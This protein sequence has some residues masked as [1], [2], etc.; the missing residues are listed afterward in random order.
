MAYNGL[1]TLTDQRLSFSPTGRLDRIVGVRELEV[2]IS[3]ITHAEI[4]GIEKNLVVEFEDRSARFAGQGAKRVFSRLDALLNESKTATTTIEFQPGERVLVQ[5][6]ATSYANGLIATRG[7]V[8]LT[9]KRIRF[10]T[11]GGLETLIWTFPELD[12]PLEAITRAELSGVRKLLEVWIDESVG[13]SEAPLS[14]NSSTA[15]RLWAFSQVLVRKPS[16]DLTGC[17]TPIPHP[18]IEDHLPT[19]ESWSSQRAASPL[20]P[21]EDST[22]WWGLA[23]T[24]SILWT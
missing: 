6:V 14:R 9:D 15:C 21:Q 12:H 4:V 3:L 8:V 13:F 16:T 18:S 7:E 11:G 24:T 1:L 2:P 23:P 17:F 19:P 10:L 20:P 22:R 5:G